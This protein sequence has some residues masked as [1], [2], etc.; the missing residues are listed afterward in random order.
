MMLRFR[1]A[2]LCLCGLSA[3]PSRSQGQ[4]LR[5]SDDAPQSS[6][7]AAE[8]SKEKDRKVFNFE[9]AGEPKPAMRY[10]FWEPEIRREPGNA[11]THML[12]A[13]VMSL[14]VAYADQERDWNKKHDN[15]FE[16]PLAD[17]PIK[18]ATAYLEQFRN[19][20]EE[21]KQAG[22]VNRTDYEL[23]IKELRGTAV[24]STL[25][26]EFQRSRDLVRLVSLQARLAIA[27]GRYDDAIQHI[28]TGFRLGEIVA[29]MGKPFIIGKLVAVSIN[30]IMLE[31]VETLLQQPGAPNLYWALATLP[32]EIGDMRD[33]L[34]GER[35]A[36]ENT[37]YGIMHLPDEPLSEDAWR[38]RI[39]TAVSDFMQLQGH[40]YTRRHDREEAT[41]KFM[42]AAVLLAYG[43]AGKASLRQ[44]GVPQEIVDAMSYSEA[45]VRA[46][47]ESSL[48][49]LSEY[50][51]WLLI[52][53]SQSST[54]DL[55][56]RYLAQQRE[57]NPTD[58]AVIV[59]SLMMPAF[60]AAQ[61]AGDRLLTRRNQ[62]ITVEAIRAYAAAHDG[63]LPTSLEKLE[64]LPAWQQARSNAPFEYQK[65]SNTEALL[66]RSTSFSSE[67]D[68]EFQLLLRNKS[69][70][71]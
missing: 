6:K 2:L 19:V 21:L 44:Q 28:K 48:T 14:D 69:A 24:Y 56:E 65:V 27:E 1:V 51:K 59:G 61:A 26:P 50:Y 8:A 47:R 18:D 23:R 16:Q 25:L 22:R 63:Q 36:F 71:P 10:E 49:L 54:V 7:E 46:T 53:R 30:T 29:E 39:T 11:M 34:E 38:E 60:Q 52:P 66:R 32:D 62:L 9:A 4:V 12:R 35:L 64:P 5:L 17:F 37:L 13:Y 43:D 33:S 40:V 57:S 42:A 20:L 3:L 55:A 68:A 58:L 70:K 41:A 45:T 31:E 67:P 15:V